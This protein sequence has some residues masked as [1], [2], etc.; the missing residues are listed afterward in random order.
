MTN[1][2]NISEKRRRILWAKGTGSLSK[3]T[4]TTQSDI[5]DEKSGTMPRWKQDMLK[6]KT[7]GNWQKWLSNEMA[8]TDK[9]GSSSSNNGKRGNGKILSRSS[10]D[11][12][13]ECGA[14]PKMSQT[15]AEAPKLGKLPK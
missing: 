12:W 13:K 11:V 14:L 7:K 15:F 4:S 6:N 1:I 8:S 10:G 5:Q 3:T 9:S 2:S